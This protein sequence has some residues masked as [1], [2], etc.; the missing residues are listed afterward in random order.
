MSHRV[1]RWVVAPYMLLLAF[2]LNGLLAG[3]EQT[4]G[5]ISVLFSLQVLFYLVAFMGYLLQK[6]QLRFRLFF[7]PYYFC[8][9]NYS[10][11]KGLAR[12]VFGRQTVVWERVAR[13]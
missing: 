8:V 2:V 1:F 6:Q 3:K 9:M 7:V 5:M 13:R 12:Y 4:A 11:I 10:M